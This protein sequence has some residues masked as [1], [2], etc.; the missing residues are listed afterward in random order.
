[1]DPDVNL[2][3][4]PTHGRRLCL[5]VNDFDV[6]FR[7]DIKHQGADALSRLRKTRKDQTPLKEDLIVHA[8]DKRENGKQTFNVIN[9]DENE[10]SPI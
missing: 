3:D 4:Q 8:K 9:T 6:V 2:Q 7:A 5:F 1:M 10:K